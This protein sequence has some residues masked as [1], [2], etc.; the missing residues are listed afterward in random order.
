[1]AAH[2]REEHNFPGDRRFRGSPSNRTATGYDIV[3]QP[4]EEPA[5]RSNVQRAVTAEDRSNERWM[6]QR[7]LYS[8]FL[9]D[10]NC[11]NSRSRIPAMNKLEE[12][13]L[14][15]IIRLLTTEV[16]QREMLA[17]DDALRAAKAYGFIFTM[18]E[19][20]HR[21][22][23]QSLREIEDILFPKGADTQN[24]KNDVEIVFN[25]AK[26]MR[27]L[28][29]TDGGS[30]SQPGGILGNRTRLAQR[31][32]TVLTPDEAVVTVRREI[33]AR[34]KSA[35]KMAQLLGESPPEWVG[36]D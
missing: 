36:Q 20:T 1:M 32:I 21:R 17:G 25:A 19:L 16:A 22:E 12:W 11:V 6:P 3:L 9:I 27:P 14:L 18:S 29:T 13:S 34:D 8:E 31:G 24:K 10:T 5:D 23:Q 7:R 26:Y 4:T 30:K 2:G 33:A 35:V 15:G 28:I